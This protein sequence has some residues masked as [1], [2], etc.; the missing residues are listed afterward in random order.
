MQSYIDRVVLDLE[1]SAFNQIGRTDYHTF[2]DEF[3]QPLAALFEQVVSA[4]QMIEIDRLQCNIVLSR[5]DNWRE[6]LQNK[7]VMFFQEYLISLPLV[8]QD[9][10]RADISQLKEDNAE[11]ANIRE[12]GRQD[13]RDFLHYLVYG[14]YPWTSDSTRFTWQYLSADFLVQIR[15][16]Q[17]YLRHFARQYRSR[18]R[19]VSERLAWQCPQEL[20]LEILLLLD[21][22]LGEEAPIQ[23]EAAVSG[24]EV[25]QKDPHRLSGL[26]RRFLQEILQSAWADFTGFRSGDRGGRIRKL[27]EILQ[28]L[29]PNADWSDAAK[30]SNEPRAVNP[31]VEMREIEKQAATVNEQMKKELSSVRSEASVDEFQESVAAGFQL[32]YA[33]ALLLYPVMTDYFIRSGWLNAQKQFKDERYRQWAVHWWMLAATGQQSV[34]EHASAIAKLM[35]GMPLSLPLEPVPI[36]QPEDFRQAA[37]LATDCSAQWTGPFSRI[38]AETLRIC[39]LHRP[40]FARFSANEWHISVENDAKDILLPQC[41]PYSVSLIYLPWLNSLIHVGW[42]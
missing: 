39:F 38:D 41:V 26:R 30:T 13:V 42:F 32:E 27:R 20:S 9:R 36:W 2:D 37:S 7:I 3:W 24:R 8:S 18:A 25:L 15:D 22:E 16:E 1:E 31:P 33:G 34:T 40:G 29:L 11:P 23:F 28:I 10:G 14:I 35:C 6:E 21:P 12:L 5:E 4:G 17:D 19:L